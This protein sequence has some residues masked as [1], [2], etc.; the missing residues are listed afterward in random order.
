MPAQLLEWTFTTTLAAATLTSPPVGPPATE[1][2]DGSEDRFFPVSPTVLHLEVFDDDMHGAPN[3]QAWRPP[4]SEPAFRFTPIPTHCNARFIPIPT[5]TH[6]EYEFV[7]SLAIRG[8]LTLP[9]A[10]AHN[11]Q[12]RWLLLHDTLATD[13]EPPVQTEP[14]PGRRRAT[15]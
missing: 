9:N 7:S 6:A 3:G 4:I 1:W 10:Q 8:S 12:G 5:V 11:P 13:D 14:R 2:T 15:R